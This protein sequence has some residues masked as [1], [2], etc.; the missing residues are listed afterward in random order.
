MAVTVSVTR[1]AVDG[2]QQWSIAFGQ[3]GTT[4][5]VRDRA[6]GTRVETSVRPD[7]TRQTVEYTNGLAWRERLLA[8]DGA[9]VREVVRGHDALRLI[10]W[11]RVTAANGGTRATR[12]T[13]DAFGQLTNQTE[14]AGAL[15]RATTYAYD[16]LGQLTRTVL[17]DGGVVSNRYG[18]RGE[19]VEQ[20]GARVYPVTHTY[21]DEGR[22]VELATYRQGRGGAAD[23]TRWEYDAARGWLTA[24]RYADGSVV[25][26]AYD[27]NGALDRK[28]T[29]LNSSHRT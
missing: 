29:R 4:S 26:N 7:G 12:F 27:A 18:P 24:K 17:P 14:T 16:S 11:E 15:T 10:E 5:V 1:A 23:T 19:L 8:A 20:G 22:L 13:Y 2:T 28:S 3:T 21:D 9:V 25:S 6:G